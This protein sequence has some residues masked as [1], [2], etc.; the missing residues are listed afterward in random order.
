MRMSQETIELIHT[1]YDPSFRCARVAQGILE[2]QYGIEAK[3]DT[4]RKL[5][6]RRDL[7]SRKHSDVVDEHIRTL[8]SGGMEDE[9]DIAREL[10]KQIP[11]Y[12]VSGGTVRVRMPKLGIKPLTVGKY[13][14]GL[15]SPSIN[16]TGATRRTEGRRLTADM[17]RRY[18]GAGIPE[19]I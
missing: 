17:R 19:A 12:S 3:A 7:T 6:G 2:E 15:V 11:G 13:R 9:F 5:W 14:G 16:S 1:L 4:I 10:G 8:H 18:A